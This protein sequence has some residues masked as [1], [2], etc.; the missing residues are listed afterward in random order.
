MVWKLVD[1]IAHRKKRDV[2]N[3]AKKYQKIF[4]HWKLRIKKSKIAGYQL[5]AQ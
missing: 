5:E 4:P 2:E 1:N 3:E